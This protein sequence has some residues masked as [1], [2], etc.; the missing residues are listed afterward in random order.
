MRK[1]ITKKSD[2]KQHEAFFS[3]IAEKADAAMQEYQQERGGEHTLYVAEY[4]RRRNY[5][6]EIRA[7]RKGVIEAL[8][9]VNTGYEVRAPTWG[10]KPIPYN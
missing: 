2:R 1:R 5:L 6:F 3:Q 7:G 9:H 10:A 4:I 8:H